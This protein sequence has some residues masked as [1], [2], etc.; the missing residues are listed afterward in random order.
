LSYTADS[1]TNVG[2]N[3]ASTSAFLE[4]KR[5][6]YVSNTSTESSRFEKFACSVKK[7]AETPYWQIPLQKN[8]R[9]HHPVAEVINGLA[10]EVHS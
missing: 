3:I 9:L 2:Q 7:D 8:N 6:L 1:Q 4:T 10:L 5:C